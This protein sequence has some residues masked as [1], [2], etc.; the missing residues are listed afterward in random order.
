ML[1]INST[2]ELNN[3]VQMPLLGL[4]VFRSKSGEE[5]RAAV[6]TALEYGYRHIDTARIYCNEKSVGRGI[7]DSGLKRE[8]VFVTTK[9][10]RTDYDSPRRGLTESL[11]RLGLD[12]VDLYLLHW[13]FVGFER[14]YLELEQLQRE[15]LCR[16]I[17]VS[18]FKIHHFAM[19][20]A[21]GATVM[22]QVNQTECHPANA[23]NVLLGWSQAHQVALEAYSP[24][25]GQG[26]LL[27]NDPRI[28]SIAAH[29]KVSAA[30]VILR[31]NLQRGVIVIPKSVHA[32]RILTNSQLY[33]FELTPEEMSALGELDK[34][35]RRAWDPDRI[36]ARP[37]E[38]WPTPVPED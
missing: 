33:D 15:G 1:S 37:P 19:L 35:E 38:L 25:G 34:H 23:E 7:K 21:A 9:L 36:E 29:Y 32:A 22:P 2:V 31:W 5:T 8:E 18:N 14:A 10:W 20:K 4:G 28:L 26:N 16:A 30:Q 3:G 12:Y 24:L 17:G 6:R 11:A 13:P 27:I